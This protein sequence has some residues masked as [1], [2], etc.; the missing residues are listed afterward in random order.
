MKLI[1]DERMEV[2]EEGDYHCTVTTGMTLALINPFTAPACKI[3]GLK[4]AYTSA[5]SIFEGP[6]TNLLS[7]LCILVEILAHSH[8]NVFCLFF[9]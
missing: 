7:V 3:S 8:A 5:D 2:G 6:I 9:P 4:S 1:K